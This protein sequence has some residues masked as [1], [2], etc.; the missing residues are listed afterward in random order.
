MGAETARVGG[1]RRLTIAS[2]RE[3]IDGMLAPPC[4]QSMEQLPA[5][6]VAVMPHCQHVRGVVCP[7]IQLARH[8]LERKLEASLDLCVEE[9]CRQGLQRK[10]QVVRLRQTHRAACRPPC[11]GERGTT[12]PMVNMRQRFS[13]TTWWCPRTSGHDESQHA[14]QL[15]QGGAI[16]SPR[17]GEGHHKFDPAAG[18]LDELDV[19]RARRGRPSQGPDDR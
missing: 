14:P 12:Q 13:I 15:P 7:H 6:A 10:V 5:K 2:R 4:V 8:S 9:G 18:S 11:H 16:I 3:A 17:R 1:L 19:G